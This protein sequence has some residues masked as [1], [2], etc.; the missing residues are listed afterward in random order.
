MRMISAIS[1]CPSESGTTAEI[2]PADAIT[3]IQIIPI[4]NIL[5]T[6]P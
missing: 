2:I 5:L 1:G 3:S 6:S 4:W